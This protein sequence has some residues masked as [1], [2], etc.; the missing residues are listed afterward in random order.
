MKT[1][2]DLNGYPVKPVLKLLL[3]DKAAR[4]SIVFATDRYASLGE[5]Y[6]EAGPIENGLLAALEA[7]GFGLE[8][9]L[10]AELVRRLNDRWDE[11]W[12]GFP[13]P[14]AGE[15]PV[16]F[17]GEEAWK[18]YVDAPR[19]AVCCGAARLLTVRED[20][21][22]GLL[23]P[24]ARPGILD[25]KLRVVSENAE[26]EEVWRHWALRAFQSVYGYEYRGDLLL[27]GR[28]RLMTAF[29]DFREARW[30]AEAS[31]AELRRIA[32][33]IAWNLW[34]MDPETAAVP[35]AH[36]EAPYRQLS[37]FDYLSGDEDDRPKEPVPCRVFDWRGNESVTFRRYVER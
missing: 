1:E 16:R 28:L 31:N 23:S 18:K 22:G 7:R 32:N 17:A 37:L 11:E 5:R 19:L 12:F 3:A 34:Q 36:R 24:A 9:E 6:R 2:I 33:V 25:R 8:E 14:F 20:G 21:A 30:G 27:L 26:T 13:E 29:A 10:S 35:F 4:R 15:G